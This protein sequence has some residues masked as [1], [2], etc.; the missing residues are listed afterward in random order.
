MQ[1]LHEGHTKILYATDTPHV[2]VLRFKDADT[3]FN[4]K[5]R[6]EFAGKGELNNRISGII[7]RYLESEGVTSHY[8]DTVNRRD[9]RVR[10][11][12]ILPVIVTVRNITAGSL[13]TRLGLDEG[14]RLD[15][16]IVEFSYNRDDLGDPLIN[17][18][19]AVHVLKIA[20]MDQLRELR[21]QALLANKAL[22]KLWKKAGLTLVD[23]AMEFGITVDRQI[24]LADE[25]TPDTQHL[26]IQEDTGAHRDV[27]RRDVGDAMDVYQEIYE[28]LHDA[29]PAFRIGELSDV[30]GEVSA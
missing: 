14:I 16:P 6:A 22:Q 23:G 17:D 30:P 13:A 7:F 2:S 1:K 8:L 10:S 4:A 5:N 26:W 9:M 29:W 21:R 15:Q 27:F 20:T 25:V 18:D 12:D 11:V 19:H 24:V 28:R 3:T